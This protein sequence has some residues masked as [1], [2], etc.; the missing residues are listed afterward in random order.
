VAPE[1]V[2]SYYLATTLVLDSTA[3]FLGSRPVPRL[4]PGAANIGSATLT[5][6]L[7]TP[8]GVYQVFAVANDTKAISELSPNNNTRH[9]P[10]KI[11]PDLV[12]ASIT[13]P[14]SA[15]VGAT[16]VNVIGKVTNSGAGGAGT[17]TVAVYLS[18]DDTLGGDV[19]LGSQD[20]SNLAPGASVSIP[21][22]VAIP[23]S[24]T[25]GSHFLVV[26]ADDGGTVSER[27]ETNNT[28]AKA[29]SIDP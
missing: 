24:T 27:D 1:S 9:T 28:K 6:P 22:S 3:V 18:V 15:K 20:V 23:P 25:A 14:T 17:F 29:I 19:L 7:G 4:V 26:V 12:V 8:G 16:G 11:G 2:T 10:I 5:I 21:F 13:A